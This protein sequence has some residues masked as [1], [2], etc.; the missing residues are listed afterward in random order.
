[1]SLEH[2]F[3]LSEEQDMIRD[4]LRKF[5]ADVAQ[6]AA[7]AADEERAFVGENLSGLAEL[8]LLGLPVSEES[9]GLG[10]GMLSFSIALEEIAK[11][12]ASTAVLMLTQAGLCARA[13]EGIESA[14]EL[15]GEIIA[16]EKIAG[17][18]GPES[19][20]IAAESG[21]EL[22]LSGMVELCIA[23]EK[24]DLLILMAKSPEGENLLLRL[25]AGQFSASPR[26]SLG[27]RAAGPAAISFAENIPGAAILVRGEAADR[28]IEVAHLAG[29][30]GGAAIALGTA[31]SCIELSMSYAKE[32]MA[33]G[34]PLARQQAVSHK[35]VEIYR[36]RDAA[37]H[38][39]Y[40][41]AR[42]ADAGQ[43]CK[44]EAM[45]ARL[46]AQEAAVLAGDEGIQIHGGFGFTTEYHVERHYRDAKTLE[47]LHQG[48]DR[49]RDC[50]GSEIGT[51]S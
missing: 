39:T 16:G 22:S 7:L 42:L 10:L 28:A 17:F 14:S 37:R 19:G 45:M 6:P 43:D 18:V 5:V 33:F 2:N 38:Q 20:I 3:S 49:M 31:Q 9:G 21:D 29:Q 50:L 23:G 40:H 13:L 12:C 41:A 44:A 25:D 8:G 30:I 34:K 48:P 47:V 15:L 26:H 32:R 46:A 4:T 35:L 24:A 11:A 36:S 51:L 27:F 1:M